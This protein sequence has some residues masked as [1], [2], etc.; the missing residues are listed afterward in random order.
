M[1]MIPD[2]TTKRS[3]SVLHL[4][5]TFMPPKVV[6]NEN[7]NIASNDEGVARVARV[8]SCERVAIIDINSEIQ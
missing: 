4:K 3:H 8:A 1:R 7:V 5:T 6:I 2:F